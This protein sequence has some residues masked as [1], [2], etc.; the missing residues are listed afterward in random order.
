MICLNESITKE[1]PVYVSNGKSSIF[2]LFRKKDNRLFLKDFNPAEFVGE[3]LCIERDIRSAHY[4]LAGEGVYNYKS[5][6]PYKDADKMVLGIGV[7]S[8]SFYEPGFEYKAIHD[9]GLS[10]YSKDTFEQMLLRANGEENKKE[11]CN[12]LLQ[13]IALDI[14]MGQTDRFAYNYLFEE[15]KKHNIRLAPAFDFQHSLN[16][17]SVRDALSYGDLQPFHNYEECREL[18]SKYPQFGEYLESYLG[19]DLIATIRS[20]Y[21]KR[22]MIV[23][24]HVVPYYQ[25][26]EEVQKEKIK[27]IVR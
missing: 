10:A 14:Y 27:R 12:E 9:Y 22:R 2:N 18:V 19:N 4:F 5:F 26:F 23:P 25:N 17:S 7:A 11:L 13:L 16:S 6:V 1:T 24:E 8:W 3:E 21:A 15:D 20:A